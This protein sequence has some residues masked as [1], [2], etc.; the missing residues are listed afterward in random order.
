MP[1]KR[2]ISIIKPS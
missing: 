1:Y 2:N